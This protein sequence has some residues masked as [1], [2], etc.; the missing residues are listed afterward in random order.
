MTEGGIVMTRANTEY[1]HK[2][3]LKEAFGPAL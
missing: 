1:L 2:V 3:I